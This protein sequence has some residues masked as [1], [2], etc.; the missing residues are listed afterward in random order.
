MNYPDKI[1]WDSKP[2]NINIDLN[3]LYSILNDGV[4]SVIES[5]LLEEGI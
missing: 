4:M 1:A 5:R 3:E 2:E